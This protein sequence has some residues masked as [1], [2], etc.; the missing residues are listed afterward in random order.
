MAVRLTHMRAPEGRSGGSARSLVAQSLGRAA[1]ALTLFTVL[2]DPAQAG[3]TLTVGMTDGDIPMANGNP[4]QGFEGFRLV[5]FKLFDAILLRD[6][7]TADKP[8][9]IKPGLATSY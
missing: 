5:G 7:S 4:D 6:L 1:L 3:G 8:S 9:E 2:S